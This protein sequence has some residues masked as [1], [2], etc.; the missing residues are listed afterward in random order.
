MIELKN[1]DLWKRSLEALSLFISEGNFRFSDKGVFFKAMDPS[2]IVLINYAIDRNVFDKYDIEP[3]FVGMDLV[4]FS[5]IMSRSQ[6]RDRLQMNLTDSEMHINLKGEM[7]R[8]FK[9]PLLDLS[10]E[11]VNLPTTKYDVKVNVNGRILK[12]AFKD[13]S[14][15]SSSVMLKVKDKDFRVEAKGTAG[16][17]VA[18][19]KETKGVNVNGEKDVASKFSLNFLQNIVKEAPMEK[20]VLLELKSDSP[21]KVSYKIGNSPIEYYLA[22]MVL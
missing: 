20:E 10:D 16:S 6:P 2:Q 19:S 8:S 22:H 15:F 4:E 9:L 12:E 14:L 13:A 5:R 21:M 18:S 1:A 11:E 17:L 7:N 3:T